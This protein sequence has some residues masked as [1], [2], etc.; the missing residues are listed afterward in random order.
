M[1]GTPLRRYQSSVHYLQ[2]KLSAQEALTRA[3]RGLKAAYAGIAVRDP[4]VRLL[5]EVRAD[6]ELALREA[7]GMANLD[8]AAP[9]GESAA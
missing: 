7:R 6:I 5:E 1:A 2:H 8:D 3:G 9:A 4:S